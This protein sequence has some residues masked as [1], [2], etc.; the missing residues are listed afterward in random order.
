KISYNVGHQ[1]LSETYDKIAEQNSNNTAIN[2]VD[3]A[4]KL[5]HTS[6]LP[7]FEIS[8]L[9]DQVIGNRFGTSVLR[10]MIADY[11]YLYRVNTRTAQRLGQMFEIE[12]V[13]SP[14]Y[15]LPDNKKA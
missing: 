8:R 7:E 14:I 2:M 1:H 4:I 6:S 5:E 3:L 15:L 9:R 13:T 10:Q 12:G 11:L